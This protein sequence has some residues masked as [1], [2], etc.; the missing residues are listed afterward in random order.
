LEKLTLF[1]DLENYYQGINY[2]IY[3]RRVQTK[4]KKSTKHD[5]RKRH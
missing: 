5:A 1:K 4:I 3:K 2:V